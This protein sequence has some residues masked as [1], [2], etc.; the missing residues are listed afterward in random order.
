MTLRRPCPRKSDP[1]VLWL[2]AAVALLLAA[3]L[4]ESGLLAYSMYVLLGLL[5]LTR[6]L[7]R[8]GVERLSAPRVVRHARR[9]GDD[10][11]PEDEEG[12]ADGLAL[13]IGDR[14]VVVVTIRNE[15]T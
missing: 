1:A 3:L 9:K 15:G 5:L 6:W 10:V 2:L 13:E 8:A 11:P 12:V 7:T 4:L 14:F